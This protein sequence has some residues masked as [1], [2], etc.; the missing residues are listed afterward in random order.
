M[1]ENKI[2]NEKKIITAVSDGDVVSFRLLFDRYRNELYRYCF[3][4]AKSKE[5]SEEIVQD[6]FIMVWQ[7]RINIK[8]ELPIKPYLYKITQNLAFN[9]LKKAANE[10]RLKREVFYSCAKEFR[11]EDELDYNDTKT[12][13]GQAIRQMP[14]GQRKIFTM[15]REENKSQDEIAHEL[16]ISKNTVKDQIY[17]ALRHIRQYLKT[18]G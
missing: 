7:N 3:R 2:Y 17:K 1:Q 18:T 14:N 5:Q 13:V 16:N 4:V 9:F 10:E 8:P 15:S 12:L 6:V 11:P